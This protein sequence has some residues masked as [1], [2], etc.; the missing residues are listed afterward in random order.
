[1]I[2]IFIARDPYDLQALAVT[3]EKIHLR[4]LIADIEDLTSSDVLKLAI[5]MVL[6]EQRDSPLEPI[7][8][9]QVQLDVI[10]LQKIRT[11]GLPDPQALF[12]I[13]LLRSESHL[14]Q[15]AC[16]YASRT[17]VELDQHFRT[18]YM[19]TEM[20]RNV[21]V[22]AIRSVR[23]PIYRDTMLLQNCIKKNKKGLLGV[24]MVRT[25]RSNPEHWVQVKAMYQGIAHGHLIDRMNSFNSDLFRDLM[26]TMAQVP[27]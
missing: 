25:C 22:H 17:G 21:A 2:E 7:N 18:S 16:H 11:A 27:V 23:N 5:Y 4:P 24:R 12:S 14:H 1:M 3:Y 9:M 8:Q 15:V 13:L 19:F 26:V 20:T 6:R 10:E